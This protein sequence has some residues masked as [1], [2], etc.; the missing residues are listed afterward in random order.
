MLSFGINQSIMFLIL[1]GATWTLFTA[2][3]AAMF[4]LSE[5]GAG[6]LVENLVIYSRGRG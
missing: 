4:W 2:G 3:M 5:T 1:F 6:G